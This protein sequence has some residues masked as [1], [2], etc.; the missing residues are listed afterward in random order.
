MQPETIVAL[1]I[2]AQA[3]VLWL[4]IRFAVLSAL[5]K[6]TKETREES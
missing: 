4:I 2:A 5:R 3:L 1:A 6:H